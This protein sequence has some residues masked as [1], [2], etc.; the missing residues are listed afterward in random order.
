MLYMLFI[1]YVMCHKYSQI[2]EDDVHVTTAANHDIIL[3]ELPD[4]SPF[5]EQVGEHM[6]SACRSSCSVCVLVSKIL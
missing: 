3:V 2:Y 5:S 6:C 4:K 1:V